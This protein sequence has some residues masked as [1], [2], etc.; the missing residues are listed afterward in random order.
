[1]ATTTP[2]A[3]IMSRR[4]WVL[5][6]TVSVLWGI[7]Y[8][9][10]KTALEDLGPVSVAAAR[11]VLGAAALLAFVLRPTWPRV[12]ARRWWRLV[13]LALVEV[14]VPFTLIAVGELT[15]SSAVTGVLIAAEPLFVAVLALRLA[16]SE[17]LRP[18]GW[19]GLGVGFLGVVVLLGVQGAGA[20]TP[21]ILL[22]ALS[23]A[24]GALLVGRWFHDVPALTVVGAMLLV[25]SGPLVV[26]AALLEPAPTL[27]GQAVGSVLV[28]GFVCTAGGFTAF[29][30]LINQAG[31]TRAA[32]ITYAAPIVA[33]SAG[34]AVL[35]EALTL[36]TLAGAALILTGAAL[37]THRTAQ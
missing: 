15:V 17:R 1:M 25:A 14:M 34:V 7:P 20:G 31:P 33:V 22:A 16:R 6:A 3:R 11:V 29:F 10:I 28:L 4:G 24:L 36:R 32:L 2:A 19:L 5:F 27:T 37:V 13:I 21:L 9:F 12:L 8:L 18:R 26:L 35:H 23:Y 30:A